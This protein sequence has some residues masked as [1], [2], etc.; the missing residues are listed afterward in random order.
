MKF[1]LFS[2][3]F[4]VSDNAKKKRKRIKEASHYS[5]A[6]NKERRGLSLSCGAHTDGREKTPFLLGL[7]TYTTRAIFPDVMRKSEFS[8]LNYSARVRAR[9]AHPAC[10]HEYDMTA[11]LFL[12]S[13][14]GNPKVWPSHFLCQKKC[15]FCANKRKM[16]I[17]GTS[18]GFCY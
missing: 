17:M 7:S 10:I 1:S 9:P 2:F 14:G 12:R 16:L 5:S 15:N 13:L 18:A 3:R 4:P 6:L 8:N 11:A